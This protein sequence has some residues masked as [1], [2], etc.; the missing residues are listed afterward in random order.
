MWASSP[1]RKSEKPYSMNTEI[2]TEIT[3]GIDVSQ[4]YLDVYIRPLDQHVR[5]ENERQ[6]IEGLIQQLKTHRPDR[7]LIESTGRLELPFVCAASNVG[8]P[9][10][11]CDAAKV[12]QFAKAAGRLAKTDQLDAEDIAHY[13]DALKPPLTQIKP[14]ELRALSDLISV[15]TQLTE[16]RTMQKNRL[17][18]MPKSVHQPLQV[19]LNTIDRQ[20]KGIDAKLLKLIDSVDHWRDKRD[21]LTSA[22]SIGDVVAI[23]LLSE[24]PEL[25]QLNRKQIAA[26]VGV[27]PM[28]RDSGAYKGKR[29]I[30]GGRAKV[31]T[32]LFLS[33]M[34]AIQ[35]HPTLKPMYQRLVAGGKPKK[36]AIVACMR[37]QLTILNA[38]VK[39]GT[40]WDPNFSTNT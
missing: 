10:V 13:G 27:A 33:T 4:R 9:V 6:A 24:L 38:M 30:R 22:H 21:L 19:V 12:R 37:K 32:A 15:R 31:R 17:Q 16:M 11:V 20:L 14:K 3:I 35:H 28:N 29:M 5:V 7:V 25:G 26:L 8:L 2:Q 40:A 36:V 18:R 34:T 1:D 39:T 23:T